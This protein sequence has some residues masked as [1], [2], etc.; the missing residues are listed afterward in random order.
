M[1][2]AVAPKADKVIFRPA[3]H[4]FFTNPRRST[5]KNQAGEVQVGVEVRDSV[6]DCEL[7]NFPFWRDLVV[8]YKPTALGVPYPT[9]SENAER[10][11]AVEAATNRVVSSD[12]EK[13]VRAAYDA[14]GGQSRKR[15][16]VCRRSVIPGMASCPQ[17]V[18]PP[19]GDVPVVI[20]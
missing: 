15:H 12:P 2:S 18:K 11:V 16:R 7:F 10:P 4:A 20:V 5:G 13:I 19:R 8:R 3:L 1:E 9:L 6:T 14:L 17:V